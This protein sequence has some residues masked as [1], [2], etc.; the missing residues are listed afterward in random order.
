MNWRPTSCIL[1]LAVC[2]VPSHV[3]AQDTDELVQAQNEF[4]KALNVEDWAAAIAAGQKLVQLRPGDP[5]LAYNLACVHARS[6][7]K[8]Q[9]V[10]WLK[11]AADRGFYFT[12][13]L[14][15]DEDLDPIHDH[16]AFREAL[17]LIGKNNAAELEK[18]KRSHSNPT[19]ITVLPS[20]LDKAGPAPLIVALHGRGATAANMVA[21]WRK[22]A[23][24]AGAI[25]IAPQAVKDLG[26]GYDWGV[27]EQG[28]WLVLD[29]IARAKAKHKI[30]DKKIVLTGFSQGGAM[31]YLIGLR[32]PELFAGLIPMAGYYEH[33]I[34]PIPGQADAAMNGGDRTEGVRRLPRIYIMYGELDEDV[35]NNREAARQLEAIGAPH[36][37][38]IHPGV[39]HTFPPNTQKELTAA[40]RFVLGN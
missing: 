8:D 22:V 18:F 37:L 2:A 32:H 39:G 1:A 12:A 30:D 4:R 17:A 19:V 9:A 21:V 40:V 10:T 31:T 13:T 29:A 5:V 34:A 23:D 15:R 26:G 14:L 24:E 3:F 33:R 6:G 25:L 28:E 11:V 36:V 20:G 7:E 35:E 16:P 27:V 38:K